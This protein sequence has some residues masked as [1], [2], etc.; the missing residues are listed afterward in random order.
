MVVENPGRFANWLGQEEAMQLW[1]AAERPIQGAVARAVL[2]KEVAGSSLA[3]SAFKSAGE[4]RFLPAEVQPGRPGV[5][6]YPDRVLWKLQNYAGGPW[7]SYVRL[8]G[9]R[10]EPLKRP[11]GGEVRGSAGRRPRESRKQSKMDRNGPEDHGRNHVK[12]SFA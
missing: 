8:S 9:W 12:K 2:A 11:A 1:G 4:E 7:T 3:L 5:Q 6:F 10:A